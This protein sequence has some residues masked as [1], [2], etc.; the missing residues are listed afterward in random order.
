ML[1]MMN[2]PAAMAAEGGASARSAH[3]E[4]HTRHSAVA[5][6]QYACPM[7]PEVRQREPGRCP[8]CGMDLRP[9]R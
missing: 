4:D 5:E 1:R 7:H 6:L 2:E 9:M 3:D 8:K